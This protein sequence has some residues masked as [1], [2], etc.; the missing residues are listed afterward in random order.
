MVE[1]YLRL[2]LEALRGPEE[3]RAIGPGAGR[4]CDDGADE[5]RRD[6]PSEVARPPAARP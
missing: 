3:R 4:E 1:V 6:R 2:D 5:E